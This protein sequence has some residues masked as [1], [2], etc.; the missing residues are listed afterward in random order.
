MKKYKVSRFYIGTII[1]IIPMPVFCEAIAIWADKSDVPLRYT[2]PP[3]I[4]AWSLFI[5]L[6]IMALT[7]FY[8]AKFS[9][10][11]KGITLYFPLKKYEYLWSDFTCAGII[12]SHIQKQNFVAWVYFSKDPLTPMEKHKFLFK[13]RRR[14]D[15]LAYFQFDKEEVL[16]M[17][18][19]VLPENLRNDLQ[20]DMKFVLKMDIEK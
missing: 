9:F 18:M 1:T 4:C 14:L 16:D 20:A 7:D 5:L 11:D 3:H 10:S 13:T 8:F 17:V 19:A 12:L 2:L 15:R 6:L